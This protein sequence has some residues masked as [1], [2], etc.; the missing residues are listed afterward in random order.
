MDWISY[1]FPALASALSGV[2]LYEWKQMAGKT[3]K[4]EDEIERRDEALSKGVKALLQERLIERIGEYIAIG[5]ASAEERE[6]IEPMYQAYKD[7][8]GNG[9]VA[10]MYRK[11]MLL[12]TSKKE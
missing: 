1:I 9:T 10:Q 2:L 8:S 6:F 7:L 3:R 12:P 11:L 4:A 5:Y